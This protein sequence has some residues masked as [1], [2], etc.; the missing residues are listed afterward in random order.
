M[1]S[2][3]WGGYMTIEMLSRGTILVS[4][5]T[6]DMRRFRLS[7]DSGAD[8]REGLTELLCHVGEVCSLDPS[9]K[10]FLVEALPKQEGWFLIISVRS[11]KRRRMFRIKRSQAATVCV[12]RCADDLLDFLA[13]K[14]SFDF[15]LYLY[16][17]RYTLL[18][19][20]GICDDAALSEYGDLD[21]LSRAAIARVREFGALLLEKNVQR[22]HISGRTVAVRNAALGHG[23]GT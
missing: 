19:T 5:D 20:G 17:D 14:P 15:Q 18:P 11:V 10:S 6:Q 22:R 8:V 13:A 3:E 2:R 23:E 21:H 16:R 9:G 12:F 4:L 7:L 1:M